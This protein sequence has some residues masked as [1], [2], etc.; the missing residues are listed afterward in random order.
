MSASVMRGDGS[1][2]MTVSSMLDSERA[3]VEWAHADA[4]KPACCARTHAPF[5]TLSGQ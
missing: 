4:I 5:P 2:T 3:A 1:L